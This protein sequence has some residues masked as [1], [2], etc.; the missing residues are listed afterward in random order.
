MARWLN[1]ELK[2]FKE[3]ENLVGR[4]S[5]K[6]EQESQREATFRWYTARNA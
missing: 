3:F 2:E 1:K 5:G 4:G 6:A